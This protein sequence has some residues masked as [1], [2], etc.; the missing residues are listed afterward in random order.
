MQGA[1]GPRHE[2]TNRPM[3][4]VCRLARPISRRGA[5]HW[6]PPRPA[7]L[8][9]FDNLV[10]RRRH[11]AER[12][13]RS[14]EA[15]SADRGEVSPHRGLAD[16]CGDFGGVG[17]GAGVT[18]A[19]G[20]VVLAGEHLLAGGDHTARPEHPSVEQ[21]A[22]RLTRRDREIVGGARLP[23]AGVLHSGSESDPQFDREGR[24]WCPCLEGDV[25]LR[26]RGD[27]VRV[28]RAV[29]P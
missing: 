5:A 25:A 13:V 8:P 21:E 6:L 4:A 27:T 23:V 12:A 15:A 11:R 14:G 2:K 26:P 1:R 3:T 16:R 18:S 9:R 20:V 22:A 10:A 28:H 7:R 29:R 17:I 19:V 24:Q